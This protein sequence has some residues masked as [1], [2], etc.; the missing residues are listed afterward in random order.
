[1]TSEIKKAVKLFGQFSPARKAINTTLGLLFHANHDN[2]IFNYDT[3]IDHIEELEISRLEFMSDDVFVATKYIDTNTLYLCINTVLLAVF[4]G[5]AT[6]ENVF[7][8]NLEYITNPAKM[9]VDAID[10]TYTNFEER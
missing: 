1:M 6:I 5:G 9:I 10:K 7:A 2:I 8:S 3:N 4:K